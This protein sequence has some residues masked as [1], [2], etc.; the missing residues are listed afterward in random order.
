MYLKVSKLD[1]AKPRFLNGDQ[2]KRRKRKSRADERVNEMLKMEGEIDDS[3]AKVKS[4]HSCSN[5]SRS[6]TA[7]LYAALTIAVELLFS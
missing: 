7:L 6:Y 3:K 4:V 2:K 1:L 5:F